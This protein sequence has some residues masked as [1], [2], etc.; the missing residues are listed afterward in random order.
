MEHHT[1]ASTG[2]IHLAPLIFSALLLAGYLTL[3]AVRR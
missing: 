3:L 1:Q 2:W